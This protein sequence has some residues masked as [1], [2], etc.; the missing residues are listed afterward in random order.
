[1]TI[2]EVKTFGKCFLNAQGSYVPERDMMAAPG[3]DNM[4]E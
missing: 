3:I 2:P 4:Q 1:M